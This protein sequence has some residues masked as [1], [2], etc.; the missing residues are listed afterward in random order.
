MIAQT[1][2]KLGEKAQAL[3]FYR[4][5]LGSNA[6]NPPNAYARPLAKKKSS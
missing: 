1:Y 6:H 2:E 4:K 5:A 3:E